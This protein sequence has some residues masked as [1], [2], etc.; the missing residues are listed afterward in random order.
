[1]TYMFQCDEKNS[2][3]NTNVDEQYC[4]TEK[5]VCNDKEDGQQE[6]VSM[7]YIICYFV[8]K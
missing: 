4:S 7:G 8:L 3:Y 1:M 2:C 6:Y 5:F